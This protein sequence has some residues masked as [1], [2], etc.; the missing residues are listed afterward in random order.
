[1]DKMKFGFRIPSIKKSI[2]A[3]TKGQLTRAIKSATNPLYGQK[4]MGWINNPE[5]ALYNTIYNRTTIGMDDMMDST[6]NIPSTTET[7]STENQNIRYETRDELRKN[8]EN[9]IFTLESFSVHTK[10]LM[11]EQGATFTTYYI[12]PANGVK[13]SDIVQLKDDIALHLRVPKISIVINPQKG[14]IGIEV[15]HRI[16]K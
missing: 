4:G 14:A 12:Q 9:I 1:M 11:V 6:H 16:A 15:E 13:I 5:K 7:L 8:A 3:S 10:L 2:S